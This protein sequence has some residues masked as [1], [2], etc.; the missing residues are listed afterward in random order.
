MTAKDIIKKAK[1]GTLG[2]AVPKSYELQP[3]ELPPGQATALPVSPARF[4]R[5]PQRQRPVKVKKKVGSHAQKKA[6]SK[7]EKH[8]ARHK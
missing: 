5:T 2:K 7:K 8:K 4:G 3:D 1:A 6:L